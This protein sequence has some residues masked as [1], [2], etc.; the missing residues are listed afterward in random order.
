[1]A[2]EQGLV[3][4]SAPAGADLSAKQYYFVR[5]SATGT[6]QLC[7]T[8]GELPCGILQNKP[9]SGQT[10]CV[11]YGGVS[12]L[13]LG[14]T[15]DSND[16][17]M[18]DA[19]GK[20]KAA[21]GS[22]TPGNFIVGSMLGGGGVVNDIQS[23]LIMNLGFFNNSVDA[24]AASDGSSHTFIDQDVTSG[25]APVF[26]VTNFT[27]SAAGIDSDAATHIASDGS[28][29]TFIDQ[30]VTSGAA[31]VFAV[32]NMTGSAAG[33]DSDAATHIASD[34]SDHTF[35]DQDVTSGSA[36]VFAVTNFTGSAAGIDSDAATHIA[37]DGSDHTFID[38]DVT[39]GA[40]PVF[41][42]TNFTGSAAGIDSDATTHAAS[43][44][45]SH[46]YIQDNI[47]DAVIAVA[48]AT[49][50]A[51]GAALT[52]DI[53]D[54]AGVA[55]AK[56]CVGKIIAS[57]SE[58]GGMHD[59]NANVT[60]GTAT[61]GSILAQAAGFCVFKTDAAGQFACTATNAADETVWFNVCTS[62]GGADAV[63]NGVLVRGCD[64]DDATW[65]A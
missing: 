20:G 39:S 61:L 8:E 9:T 37:S 12:K 42:V 5:L 43:A 62:D 55:L 57:D 58:Y 11:A 45:I 24:H 4:F 17:V 48:N 52:V 54:L 63:A 34:G 19:N 21:A 49:G 32:T 40:A 13:V 29:H 47:V 1:M 28:D 51:T 14:G 30:D 26:A 46:S 60:F 41:A 23:C 3:T 36:P 18:T 50:G 53:N 33:L 6:V 22:T 25:A 16:E 35:I 64:P 31:P 59:L 10:A 2:S 38:Q 65:S 56:T 7:D 44:G 27:G 15:V